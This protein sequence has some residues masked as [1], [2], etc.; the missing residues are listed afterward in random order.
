VEVWIKR[1]ADGS[2]AVALLNRGTETA[3]VAIHWSELG[4]SEDQALRVRDLW[5]QKNLGKIKS[6]FSAAVAGHSVVVMKIG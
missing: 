4:V 6:Q 5:Q 3:T 1:L 2:R